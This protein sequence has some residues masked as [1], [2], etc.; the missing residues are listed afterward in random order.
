MGRPK[1]WLPFGGEF[2]LTR[3]VRQLAS[4]V[5]PVAVVAAR[6]QPL[7]PL[8][9][10]VAVVR[11][12]YDSLGPLAGLATGMAA[13]RGQV[14]A[15][16]ATSCDCPFLNPEFVRY[17]VAS[18][19][20]ADLAIPRDQEF[21]HPLAAAYRIELEPFIRSLIAAGKLRPVGLL[22]TSRVREI[23]VSE[24]RHVDDRL[25]SLWNINT[26]EE[27]NQALVLLTGAS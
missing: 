9:G 22:E 12:E 7:P 10:E 16:Y 19:G 3:V 27:Y 13:L 5:R 24:L 21:H 1:A 4:A 15:V 26:P 8:P 18:L 23:D 17:V 25:L 20:E 14:D 2:M 6:D 11:D